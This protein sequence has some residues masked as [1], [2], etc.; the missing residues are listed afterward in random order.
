MRFAHRL[1]ERAALF[2][3][4]VCSVVQ[5]ADEQQVGDLLH[6]LHR[7]GDAAGPEG[8]PDG[9]DLAAEFAGEHGDAGIGH[10]TVAQHFAGVRGVM[11]ASHGVSFQ[12]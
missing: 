7:V 2:S 12:W 3:S 9:V 6:H 11:H 8:V 4:R 10:R 5:A 1:L